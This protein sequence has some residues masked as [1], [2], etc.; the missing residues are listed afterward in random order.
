M[1]FR[2]Q[3]HLPVII[4]G[5]V[6]QPNHILGNSIAGH[7]R[8]ASGAPD[9]ELNFTAPPSALIGRQEI[10]GRGYG[11]GLPKLVV[12]DSEDHVACTNP[13]SRLRCLPLRQEPAHLLLTQDG[14]G[15]LALGFYR[16]DGHSKQLAR[17]CFVAGR[18]CQNRLRHARGASL[19]V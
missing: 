5:N 9:L 17:Y 12:Q 4:S 8:N 18:L 10:S 19:E 11:I 2:C 3:S 14:G 6:R 1:R 7:Q 13:A 16:L 15:L